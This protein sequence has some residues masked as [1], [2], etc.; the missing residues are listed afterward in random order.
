MPPV[1]FFFFCGVNGGHA[2]FHFASSLVTVV[3]Q[4]GQT[5]QNLI[6]TI[7]LKV[8]IQSSVSVFLFLMLNL[9][10]DARRLF[11]KSDFCHI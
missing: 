5:D 2:L 4:A 1:S 10:L 8:S 3:W 9:K 11:R 7:F 6:L